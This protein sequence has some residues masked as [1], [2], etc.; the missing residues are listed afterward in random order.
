MI[1]FSANALVMSESLLINSIVWVRSLPEHELGPTR[2]ILEDL[3]S[4]EIANGFKVFEFAIST[5]AE[6]VDLMQRLSEDAIS[7]LRPILHIDTHGSEQD[8]LILAPS[9]ERVTWSELINYLRGLNIATENN[10]VCVLALCFGLHGYK[11]VSL[12][13]AVPAYLFSAPEKEVTV[14]FLESE[15][16]EFYRLANETGNVTS[17]FSQTLGSQ[18]LSFHCQGLFFQ[19]LLRYLQAHCSHKDRQQRLERL[20]TEALEQ[21]KNTQPTSGELKELR[22]QIKKLLMPGQHIVDHFA[23][24]FLIGRRSLFSYADIQRILDKDYPDQNAA[25]SS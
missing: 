13:K 9:G 7:G 18:M 25:K 6:F 16:A 22:N 5:R 12:S 8:G 11:G 2:R 24:T 23:P 4:Q 3:S 17:A 20:L 1:E 15:T 19:A 10:L 14:G 21:Q